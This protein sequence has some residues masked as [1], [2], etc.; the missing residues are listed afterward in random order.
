M[1][2]YKIFSLA[3]CTDLFSGISK[4]VSI[5]LALFILTTIAAIIFSKIVAIVEIFNANSIRVRF[6]MQESY[7]YGLVPFSVLNI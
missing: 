1:K 3:L 6:V 4:C 2:L 7:C 5:I